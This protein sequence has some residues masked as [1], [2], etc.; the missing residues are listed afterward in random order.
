MNRPSF[1]SPLP[2]DFKGRREHW[3]VHPAYSVIRIGLPISIVETGA[4]YLDLV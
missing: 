1:F 2:Q 3:S 4:V